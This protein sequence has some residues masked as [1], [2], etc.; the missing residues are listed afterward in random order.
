[1]PNPIRR[2]LNILGV[3]LVILGLFGAGLSDALCAP[4]VEELASGFGNPPEEAKPWVYWFWLNGNITK[5]G[6]TA[7]L[8]AMKRV[9]IGGVLIMEVDQG[10]PLGPVDFMSDPW[11]D[12]FRHVVAESERLG[13]QVNMNND[14]GWNGS[15]GPWIKPEESMQKVV[16]SEI[17]V[18]GPKRFEGALPQPETVA[19]YYR[20][21][22]LLAFPSPGNYRI[23]RIRAKACYNAAGSGPAD[24]T[25]LPPEMRIEQDRVIDLSSAMAKDGHLA[26]D[27]PSGKWTL[28]RFGHTS[29]GIENAPSPASGRGL[30]CDKLSKEGIEAN[31]NGMMGKLIAD[32]GGSAGK[33]LV[34]THIDSW[35]NGA[36]NW[37]MKMREEF[38]GRRGYDPLPYLPVITGRV[39]ETLEIS[40]RFLWDLR[41]TISDLV[42]ENYAGHLRTLAQRHGLRLS[43]EAY[44]GPCDDLPYAGQA[45]EPM[46]EF[47]M[48]GGAM[49][50]CKEMASAAHIYGKPILGAEAFTAGDEEKWKEHPASIKALGDQAFCDGVNR[51]VF[52]RYA[53]QPWLDRQPGMTMG[54][55][56]IHYER[57]QTWWEWS[58]GWHEYLARCQYLLRQGLFVADVCFLQ[59]ESS[60]QGFVSHPPLPYDYDNCSADVLL[61]RMTVRDGKLALPDGLSYRLL[62]LPQLRTM[63]PQLLGKIKEL[64]AA[65]ATVIG[66][67]PDRAPGLSDYPNCDVQ[68]NR[69]AAEL[70]GEGEPSGEIEE[71]AY[72]KGRVING[73]GIERQ[74][75]LACASRNPLEQAKWI[76]HDEG[77]PAIE[78]P[79]A[80]RFFR[81]TL[82][83]E[84]GAQIESARVVMTADNAFELWINGQPVGSGEEINRNHVFDVTALV[85]PGANT[86]AVAAENKRDRPN[87][88]G[89]ILSL[90]VQLV[91]GKSLEVN[92]DNTWESGTTAPANWTVAEGVLEGWGKAQELGPLG[93]PPWDTVASA[94]SATFPDSA[95]IRKVLEGM[96]VPPD[97]SCLGGLRYIHRAVG[98]TDLYFVANPQP[99]P[100]EAVCAF[101]VGDKHPEFW[102]PE[103]GVRERAVVYEQR[104]DGVRLPLALGPS[105]SVFVVFRKAKGDTDPVVSVTRDG[106]P[107]LSVSE[108]S[109]KILIEKAV[110]GILG[111][112]QRTR[113]VKAKVQRLVD[114]GA[115]SFEVA[116]LAEGDDPAVNL[117]KTLEVEY[118]VNG[119]SASAKAI[120]PN[121]ISLSLP[122]SVPRPA[123]VRPGA[124][125]Q[126]VI[127]AWRAGRYELTTSS[128]LALHADVPSLPR[129]VEVRGPWEV[130]FPPNWGA[131]HGVTLEQLAS[132]SEHPD[133][134]VRHFSGTAS[135]S[136]TFDLPP[137]MHGEGKRVGLDLGKVEVMAR[138]NLNGKD[139]GVL[140]REPYRL[141][142]TGAVKPG[143]NQLKVEVVNLWVNRLIGDEQLPEDSERH[144]NGTLKEWP[145][146]V[147]EGKASPTGRFTF[148]TWRLW[149]K[150]APLKESGLLGPVTLRTSAVVSVSAAKKR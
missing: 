13:L 86:L 121:R 119:Q 109:A 89:L 110:Y 36:Q 132:W 60:P 116:R 63:T 129:P 126:P 118:S 52:H 106:N 31:F 2:I 143:K 145:S 97:F 11:R 149:G 100:V 83:V 43:I 120:D 38:S 108:R 112:P 81:R 68:V 134:G 117:V 140:W 136:T 122:T 54:P 56:G 67:K 150:D 138:V 124:E 71:R 42:V 5:E 105:E 125:G 139:L 74:T 103:S 35:E 8:E 147:Q 137:D 93:T 20:D 99:H 9:G 66:P 41:Q 142:V 33:T 64:V 128:G 76:W 144:P 30:E 7:D 73:A 3:I 84:E 141:D 25:V 146:W 133:P 40:E 37:T 72:G 61:T 27:V 50:T 59:P 28:V 82:A 12:L 14:A 4:T 10:V 79:V 57:T 19:G 6:I 39:V 65:G 123:E 24:Q 1:M 80:K 131:P 49:H 75:D 26:W 88:A 53:M 44:G 104:D 48:G 55:W 29:T 47:W 94:V 34:A 98:D 58:A 32:V 70:W 101:R 102:R 114:S 62:V 21:I 90:T 16:W 96:G 87:P 18:E 45:D 23:G 51:F 69:I 92:S 46:C 77:N 113:D 78:A 22:S 115:Y 127:E 135:Y 95:V 91:G 15:G 130:R 148:T 17:E 107:V 85:K 111:D